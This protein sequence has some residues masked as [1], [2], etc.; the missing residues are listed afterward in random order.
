MFYYYACG[1]S[2]VGNEATNQEEEEKKIKSSLLHA[3]IGLNVY[4]IYVLLQHTRY[5]CLDNL[6]HS[7]STAGNKKEKKR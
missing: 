6:Q 1:N 4:V 7:F 2:I 5:C 3:A